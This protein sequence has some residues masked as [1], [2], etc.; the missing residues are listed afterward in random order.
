[1]YADDTK[2]IAEIRSG[3]VAQDTINLQNDINKIT[4]WTNTWLMRLNISKCKI[5]H[6]GIKPRKL[7]TQCKI[8]IRTIGHK[9]G[10]TESEKDLGVLI[11]D[12]LKPRNQVNYSAS[13][14]NSILGLLKRTLTTRDSHTWKKLYTCYIR[15]L[16][17]FAVSSWNPYTKQDQITLEKVK[18][19][20]TKVATNLKSLKYGKR[21][22]LLGL[23][24]LQLRRTRGD[25]I[26]MFKFESG[27]D[28]IDWHT[29]PTRIPQ[30]YGH[31]ERLR[32]EIIWCCNQRH[33]FF[34]NRIANHWNSLPDEIILSKN[35]NE[36]K[37]KL[38]NYLK[39]AT[40]RL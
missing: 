13:K 30:R 37:N 32:R 39:T 25:L 9:F 18:K 19:R 28:K 38:D 21:C 31:R 1:M 15:P 33:E 20:A 12:D 35:V 14:A 17:E 4:D 5:M 40:G 8:T 27:I 29:S 3:S 22:E 23:S 36:F 2:I 26:Q 24:S 10:K 6:V 7:T 11:S 34:S 16:I